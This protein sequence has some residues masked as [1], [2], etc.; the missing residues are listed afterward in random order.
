[1]RLRLTRVFPMYPGR[2]GDQQLDLAVVRVDRTVVMPRDHSPDLRK[3]LQ[4]GQEGLGILQA[5]RGHGTHRD[6]TMV[7][8]DHGRL[9]R[10]LLERLLK[11]AE[12]TV[13]EIP[14]ILPRYLRVEQHD[15]PRFPDH[16]AREVNRAAYEVAL[17]RRGRIMIARHT[18]HRQPQGHEQA[19]EP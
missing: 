6:G 10:G 14:M 19:A 7:E 5:T 13:T 18:V 3:S 17:H 12:F 9:P 16:A 1:G 4:K 2:R 8:G 15:L 11:S